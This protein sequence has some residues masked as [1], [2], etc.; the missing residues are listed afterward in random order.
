MCMPK[1]ILP[2][3]HRSDV[4]GTREE[5]S[6]PVERFPNPAET[7]GRRRGRGRP[8]GRA[9]HRGA[10]R[11]HPGPGDSPAAA[12]DVS[13]SDQ[14]E[15]RAAIRSGEIPGQ[16]EIVH[17]ANIEHVAHIPKDVLSGT[18]SDLAFQGKYAFA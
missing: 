8:A 16:D 3:P 5:N 18:N 7:A 17:S 9:A 10:R 1:T 13:R 2:V 14:A 4:N 6:D 15:A 12:K 11:G